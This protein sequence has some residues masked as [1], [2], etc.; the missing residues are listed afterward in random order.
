[1]IG[2]TAGAVPLRF[3]RGHTKQR[4]GF[5]KAFSAIG[6]IAVLIASPVLAT[7][8]DVITIEA[9][10]LAAISVAA[11][12]RAALSDSYARASV[13]KS[14]PEHRNARHSIR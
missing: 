14:L 6:A 8:I 1:M 11:A 12:T 7:P 10:L 13:R 2:D 4:R 3:Q 9:I 5:V